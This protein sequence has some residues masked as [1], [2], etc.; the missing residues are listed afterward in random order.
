MLALAGILL[1]VFAVETTMELADAEPGQ[2]VIMVLVSSVAEGLV[3]AY[4][5]A[6]VAL[7]VGAMVYLSAYLRGVRTIIPEAIFNR[8]VVLA[9]AG[10][11]LLVVYLS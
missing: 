9:A 11:A 1:L 10:A 8:V 2:G 5:V 6:A 7:V 3:G 4:I